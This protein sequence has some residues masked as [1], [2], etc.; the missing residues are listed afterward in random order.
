MGIAHMFSVMSRLYLGTTFSF[1]CT[2]IRIKTTGA[3]VIR[4]Y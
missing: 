4:F 1:I 3:S 2:M